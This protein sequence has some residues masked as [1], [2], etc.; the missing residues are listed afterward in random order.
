[1]IGGG[2]IPSIGDPDMD[3]MFDIKRIVEFRKL[4]QTPLPKGMA[5]IYGTGG[6]INKKDSFKEMFYDLRTKG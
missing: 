5:V 6:D 3:F 1:M 4:L 2:K